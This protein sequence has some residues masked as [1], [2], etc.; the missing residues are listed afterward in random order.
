MVKLR[1]ND[2]IKFGGVNDKLLQKNYFLKNAK[3]TFKPNNRDCD[4]NRGCLNKTLQ[5]IRKLGCE[6]LF[7]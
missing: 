1:T 4:L 5:K 3:E 7:L 6:E 2:I